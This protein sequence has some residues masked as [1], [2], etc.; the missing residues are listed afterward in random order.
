MSAEQIRASESLIGKPAG[1]VVVELARLHPQIKTM[2]F[3]RYFPNDPDE[4]DLFWHFSRD[5]VLDGLQ[6]LTSPELQTQDSLIG[7]TSRVGVEQQETSPR[8]LR[9]SEEIQHIPM[10]FFRPHV[11]TPQEQIAQIKESLKRVEQKSGWIIVADPGYYYCG[12]ELLR[13][14]EWKNFLSRVTNLNARNEIV[15]WKYLTFSMVPK[16]TQQTGVKEA[17]S[18]MRISTSPL[19]SSVP[20]VIDVL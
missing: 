9:V 5:D 2:Y 16:I 6:W 8:V 4:P 3:V 11:G 18:T 7:F 10:L 17:Y 19:N 20:K 14:N 15:P 1:E 12:T 13:E